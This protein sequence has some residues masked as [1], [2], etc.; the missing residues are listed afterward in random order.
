MALGW[1]SIQLIEV[2]AGTMKTT[3]PVSAWFGPRVAAGRARSRGRDGGRG[4]VAARVRAQAPDAEADWCVAGVLD[5]YIHCDVLHAAG[6]ARRR[7]G[8]PGVI[9]DIDDRD[10]VPEE[11]AG[12]A[13]RER[14]R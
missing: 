12:V 5:T 10:A 11:G 7:H 14:T 1:Y 4:H 2:D 13:G 8:E 9:G 6:G 3:V